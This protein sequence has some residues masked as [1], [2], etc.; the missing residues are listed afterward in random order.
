MLILGISGAVLGALAGGASGFCV[1]VVVLGSKRRR[2]RRLAAEGKPLPQDLVR[3]AFHV[4]GAMVGFVVGGSSALYVHPM[5]AGAIGGV[6]VP[7]AYFGLV[8]CWQG[9]R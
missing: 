6:A 1:A 7:V 4:P 3:P 8:A 2:N 9:M 5:L